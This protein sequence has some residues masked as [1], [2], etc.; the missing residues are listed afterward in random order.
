MPT[1]AKTLSASVPESV[2]R[3]TRDIVRNERRRQSAVV[4][5]ALRLYSALTPAARRVM[6]DLTEQYAPA[7]VEKLR[8]ELSRALLRA[9]WEVLADETAQRLPPELTKLPD[10]ALMRAVDDEVAATRRK[11]VP[12]RLRR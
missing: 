8:S 3:R 4:T 12:G 5:D 6:E 10:Q 2:Y 1:K 7:A 11:R 9:R